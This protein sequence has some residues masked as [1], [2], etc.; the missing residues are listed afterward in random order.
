M[1]FM[2]ICFYKVTISRYVADGETYYPSNVAWE[3]DLA[4][5]KM[6]LLR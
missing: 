5:I 6:F 4:L 2:I 1:A 3:N